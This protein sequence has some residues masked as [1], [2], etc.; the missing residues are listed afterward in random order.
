VFAPFGARGLNSGIADA[1][2]GTEAIAR[3]IREPGRAGPHPA[4]ETF[5]QTRRR[6]AMR[7]AAASTT[8]LK[9]LTA[10]SLTRR[11]M[12]WTAG[13]LAPFIRRTGKWMDTAPFGPPLGDRDE[14][15]MR[16]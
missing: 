11:G 13:R 15:G 5:S 16:Y 12:R 1:F 8:A 14:D 10:R 7:N 6:A 3:A 9:H 4:I 2:V